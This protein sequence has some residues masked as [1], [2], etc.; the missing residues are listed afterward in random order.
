MAASESTHEKLKRVRKPH[1]H[2]SY[3]VFKPDGGMEVRELPFVVG[4]MGDFS[5]N[6]TTPL[7]PLKE[8]NFIEI[9]RDNFDDVMRRMTPGLNMKVENTLAGD[10]SEM[11]V[12]L[13]FE[14]MT[15]F[16]PAAIAEQVPA[17]KKLLETREQL[18]ALLDKADRSDK[19]E[20]LLEQI[21]SNNDQ[22]KKASGE[23]GAK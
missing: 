17:L 4:V 15:D 2:I 9:D 5:G 23:L 6:P 16:N 8:R 19:L 12:N 1:V 21:L 7:K 20:G 22:I 14:S 18:K 11:A 3:E 13:K 10:N